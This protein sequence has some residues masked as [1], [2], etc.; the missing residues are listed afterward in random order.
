MMDKLDEFIALY[1]SKL[2][3]ARQKRAEFFV[4]NSSSVV[5]DDWQEAISIFKHKLDVLNELK[6]A[7][8]E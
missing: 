4:D 1:S 5:Y 8:S 6:I 3:H 7:L 2:E